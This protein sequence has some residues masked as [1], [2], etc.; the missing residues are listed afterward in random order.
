[1]EGRSGNRGTYLSVLKLYMINHH[2]Q[3]RFFVKL[4]LRK[5]E[6]VTQEIFGIMAV[7]NESLSLRLRRS[8]LQ[9]TTNITTHSA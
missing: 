2:E 6:L 7:P 4:V 5:C 1:M 8:E 9:E 3:L